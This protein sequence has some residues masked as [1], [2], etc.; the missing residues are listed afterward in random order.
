MKYWGNA[1]MKCEEK[2]PTV[3]HNLCWLM[4][5]TPR[6][7]EDVMAAIQEHTLLQEGNL[8][9]YPPP[10][11]VVAPCCNPLTLQPEQS[12]RRGSNP[13][14]TFE[15]HDKGLRTRLALSYF[16]DPSAWR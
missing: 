13:T 11:G 8:L 14:S 15:H 10:T 7:P 4:E 2:N 3:Y 5:D 12:G 16:C 6:Y 1:C 9:L